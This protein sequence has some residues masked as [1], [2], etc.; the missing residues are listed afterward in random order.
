MYPDNRQLLQFK[1][2]F[3]KFV[4]LTGDE[5][6][7]LQQGLQYET[8]QKKQPMVQAGKV[9]RSVG[10][11]LSGA[12]RNYHIKDG[13]EIT[14]YFCLENE[15]ISSYKSFLRQEPSVLTIEALEDSEMI[16]F[17]HQQLQEWLTHP[18]LAHKMERFGRL[19]A[20]YVICC[21]EERVTSFVLQS[22]E[23][24]YLQL[25]QTGEN[26]FQRIP[27]HYIAN[28]LG[29]TPVSL[30]RIRKRIADSI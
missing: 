6:D 4:A 7:I 13:V 23:E 24:R 19:I 15:W 11:I 8:Y 14:G 28:Y 30:S 21:Y 3:E 12:F 16:T 2:G 17:S 18:V 26:V 25:L 10:F 9:E 20:E 22:P 27:Q 1:K 5:W 29:I